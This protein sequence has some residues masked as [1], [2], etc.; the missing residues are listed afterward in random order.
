MI[1]IEPPV[2]ELAKLDDLLRHDYSR[3][4]AAFYQAAV[5]NNLPVALWRYPNSHDK[6][7]LVDFSGV[8]Q[9]TK[10]DFTQK[11]PG[12]TFAPFVNN[13]GE[14]T[15][16]IKA[17]LHLDPNGHHFY[18]ESP[19]APNQRTVDNKNQ[20]LATYRQLTV[21]LPPCEWITTPVQHDKNSVSTEAEFCTLVEEAIAYMETTGIK[22]IVASRATQIPLPPNFNPLATFETLCQRYSR[23]FVSLVSIPDVG[24]WIGASPE[25]LLSLD[26]QELRTVALA[27]T[28][29][30]PTDAPLSQITWGAKE[31]EEQA[32]VSDY[33]RGFFR[34]LA[35]KEFTEDG[36][37]TVS[38]GNIAH[39]QTEFKVK[40][41]ETQLLHLANQI[42]NDLHPTSA[43]CGMPKPEALS[44]ILEK[45]KHDRAFYS[46][47]LGPVHLNH[48]SH[49]FVNLRCMQLRR[50]NAILYIGAGITK[51][52][53]PQAEWV[54][55]I[56][57]SETLLDVL[58]P[59]L[60]RAN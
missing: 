23:A 54:E 39:L 50:N 45:E 4:L 12:F 28:Q 7:A 27:G 29:A 60:A 59:E 5:D 35:P 53:I 55:T 8:A 13:G 37:R 11:I 32:L 42:L 49:L 44:F 43:V 19:T 58:Q 38:A 20:F 14:S 6:Q 10:I 21:D 30:Q 25:V 47:F 9:P 16:F 17:S 1:L 52:S 51:D 2:L 40:M 22:K 33:I 15:L 3:A 41:D 24:T 26:D 18:A 46:G 56:L 48:Q 57:K 34:Q 36:P 31:I